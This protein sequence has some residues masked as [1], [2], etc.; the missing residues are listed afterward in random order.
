MNL[1]MKS[2]GADQKTAEKRY[3]HEIESL[4]SIT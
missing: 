2:L 4:L 3:F 1:T